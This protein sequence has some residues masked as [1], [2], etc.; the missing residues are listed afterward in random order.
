MKLTFD[1]AKWTMDMHGAWLML[2][3][4][5]L[6]DITKFCDEEM[7]EG[8]TYTA[9]LKQYRRRRSLDANAYAWVLIGK[10][11]SKLNLPKEEVYR[12]FIRDVG[13]NYTIVPIRDDAVDKWIETWRDRGLGWICEILGESKLPGYTN[14]VSYYGS[15]TYDSLQMSRF[16]SLIVGECQS[17][18]IDTMTPQEL[19]LLM[20]AYSEKHTGRK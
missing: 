5:N 2:K 19:S 8:K 16:V 17:H 10:L 9:D 3:V 7:Q 14:V 15:S 4:E 6:K 18:G 1:E 12:V 20:E 11:A 13:D